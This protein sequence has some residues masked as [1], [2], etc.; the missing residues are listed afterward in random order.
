MPCCSKH[1]NMQHDIATNNMTPTLLRV[2]QNFQQHEAIMLSMALVTLLNNQ[3]LEV[4][5]SSK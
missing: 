5:L 4:A 2:L 1:C 3:C